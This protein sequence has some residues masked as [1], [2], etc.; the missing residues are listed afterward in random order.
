[1]KIEKVLYSSHFERALRRLPRKLKKTI[2]VREKIFRK[3]CFDPRLRTHKLSGRLKNYWSFSIYT[4]SQSAFSVFRKRE[5][6][7]YRYWRPFYL[8]INMSTN[9]L[10]KII[11]IIHKYGLKPASQRELPLFTLSCIARGYT[12]L[13]RKILGFS[14]EA[15]AA[16]GGQGRFHTMLNEERVAHETGKFVENNIAKI[17][18]IAF[19]KAKNI[20]KDISLQIEEIE[21]FINEDPQKCLGKIIQFYPQYMLCIGIYNCFWRYIGNDINKS[22][23]SAEEVKKI[24]DDRDIVARLYPQI[25]KIIIKCCVAIGEKEG[26]DGD[27]LRYLAHGEISLII[28]KNFKITK[29]VRETLKS[30][31]NGYFYL[32]IEGKREEVFIDIETID[33]I[34][35][36]FF[37]VDGNGVKEIKGFVAFRRKVRGEVF[38]LQNQA[39]ADITKFKEGS[40]LVASMTHPK[41]IMLIKKSGA[42]VTDEGG[43]LCHAAIISRELQKPCIIGTRIAS[44]ILK[45]GD[46][47]EIDAD[48][49]VVRI[50]KKLKIFMI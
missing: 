12:L 41:D 9:E 2:E 23:L 19:D 15:I 21:P 11:S 31:R 10:S 38:N 35:K 7:L 39:A 14:Y 43:I 30:R 17:D 8:P 49:G 44:K 16:I 46:L 36:Q 42:I 22:K 4:L 50:L 18:Q 28:K 33:A 20:F 32:Y 27:L 47:V 37:T 3:N 40:I 45:D 29:N 6:G 48:R 1:M 24:S 26:F 13:L 5:G 25:E 34:K